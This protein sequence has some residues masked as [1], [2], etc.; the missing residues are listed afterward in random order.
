[1]ETISINTSQNVNINFALANIGERMVAFLFDM[2]VKFAYLIVLWF[3]FIKI[4][5]LDKYLDNMDG[6]S[7]AAIINLFF[8]PIYFYTLFFESLMEGQTP[9]KKVMKIK[10]IKSDAYQGHFMDYF[11]RWI[12]RLVD[13]F[14]SLGLVGILTIIINT[15]NKRLGDIVAGTAVIT[16]KSKYNISHTIL[17]D[18][19]QDYVPLYPQVVALSDNDLRIIKENFQKAIA[20][21]NKVLA[22]KLADKICEITGITFNQEEVKLSTF[23]ETIIKDYNYYTGKEF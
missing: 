11:A 15:K 20:T 3:V 8:L 10:V 1:M 18:L 9:G 12:F 17:V 2:M 7:S 21:K 5:N 14:I 13:V 23:I 16:L 19:Q 22:E 6:W 4:G